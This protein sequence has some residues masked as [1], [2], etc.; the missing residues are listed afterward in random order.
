[1]I[2]KAARRLIRPKVTTLQYGIDG[3]H[4]AFFVIHA[5]CRLNCKMP[6]STL[7]MAMGYEAAVIDSWAEV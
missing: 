7:L 4:Q 3:S 5:S 6:T 1:M 2:G